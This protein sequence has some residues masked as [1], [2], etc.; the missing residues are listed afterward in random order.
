MNSFE[1]NKV[2]GAVL[3]TC[4]A[5]LAVHIASGAIFTPAVPAK[6]GYEIAVKE[7][8]P[9]Q[10]AAAKPAEAP[11][12]TMLATASIPQGTGDTKVCL[13]CHNFEKGQGAKIG[14]DLYGVVG[15]PVASVPGFSYSAALKAKGGTWTFDALNTWL[16]NPRA[17][18]PG[19]AMT[20]AGLPSEKQRADVIDYLNSNS[21]KPLPLPAAAAPAAAPGNTAANPTATA[22]PATPATPT[23]S[24]PPPANAPA[25][26]E[27]NAPA[28]GQS[29][30]SPPAAPAGASAPAAQNPAPAPA[31]ASPPAGQ[32]AAPAP[33]GPGSPQQ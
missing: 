9:A 23:A 22:T 27:T 8:Q 26:P 33:A 3:G 6:P 32:N 28:A 19:T 5:L 21:D 7:E 10:G 25:L 15:R 31:A 1:L 11:I 14:P 18:V 16:T 13:T 29:T 30:T 24:A 2:L 20:F 4:L 17:D 12:E